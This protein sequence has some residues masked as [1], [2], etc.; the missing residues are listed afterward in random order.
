MAKIAVIQLH[1]SDK[2]KDNLANMVRLTEQAVRKGAPDVILLPE[3][4]PGTPH[5]PDDLQVLAQDLEGEVVSTFQ[6]LARRHATNIIPGSFFEKNKNGKVYNTAVFINRSGDIVHVYRKIHLCDSSGY[7]ESDFVD[8]GSE[9]AVFDTDFGRVGMMICYD[10]R[11]P[12]LSRMLANQGARVIFIPFAFAPGNI[13]PMR[14]DHWDILTRATALLNLTYTAAS[15]LYGACGGDQF[16]G[17]SC[18]IDP[19][20]TVVAQAKP[21]EDIIFGEAD[22]TYQ[23]EVRAK[24]ASLA[25][26]RPELYKI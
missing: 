11:F 4:A 17:R 9:V 21:G 19:W 26:R 25:C 14:S 13:L 15:N 2:Y 22:F 5:G 16:M 6:E 1:T 18:F 24:V 7:K 3:E 20:G 12:E 8:P 23:E 10:A